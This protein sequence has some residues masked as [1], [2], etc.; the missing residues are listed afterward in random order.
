MWSCAQNFKNRWNGFRWVA[1]KDVWDGLHVGASEEILHH[2]E[3]N[4][5]KY[6]FSLSCIY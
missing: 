1:I 5:L 3:F 4:I 6:S 2:K